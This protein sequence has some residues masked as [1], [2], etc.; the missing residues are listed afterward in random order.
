[1]RSKERNK[2]KVSSS[3][4]DEMRLRPGIERN[5]QEEGF[6]IPVQPEHSSNYSREVE[7]SKASGPEVPAVGLQELQEAAYPLDSNTG[8][9]RPD[10]NPVSGSKPQHEK[11]IVGIKPVSY[12]V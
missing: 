7:V 12:L 3:T 4:D 9:I 8:T 2:R 1:M 10:T 11:H 6:G 5:C